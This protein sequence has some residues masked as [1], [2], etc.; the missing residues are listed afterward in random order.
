MDKPQKVR[1]KPSMPG[2]ASA[3]KTARSGLARREIATSSTKGP[4]KKEPV[5]DILQTH[6]ARKDAMKQHEVLNKK[7]NELVQYYNNTNLEV[8]QANKSVTIEQKDKLASLISKINGNI[9]KILECNSSFTSHLSNPDKLLEILVKWNVLSEELDQLI[10]EYSEQISETKKP[11]ASKE[12][13][14]S[15][16]IVK[17]YNQKFLSLLEQSVDLLRTHD[18]T[19]KALNE[20][21]MH[22]NIILTKEQKQAALKI[23]K[24]IQAAIK[25]MEIVSGRVKEG[26]R[27]N[28]KE[29]LE[30]IC[31]EISEHVVNSIEGAS[32]EYTQLMLR[33]F[34][35]EEELNAQFEELQLLETSEPEEIPMP[36][37]EVK[38]DELEGWEFVES[39]VEEATQEQPPSWTKS[40]NDKLWAL[41]YGSK[42]NK[43]L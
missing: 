41:V 3:G 16:G 2:A 43:N 21:I 7:F 35:E 30:K 42:N 28:Q 27:L 9:L 1:S 11:Q 23:D 18:A 31:L 20:R 22:D 36:T 33:I 5:K 39:S 4:K 12:I 13:K 8:Q 19:R 24:E 32:Q 17:E 34:S 37:P 38:A 26:I 29:E 25:R 14:T 15:A 10:R 40:V 6:I